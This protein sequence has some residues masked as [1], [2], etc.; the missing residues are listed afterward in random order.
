MKKNNKKDN[1]NSD[2][3]GLG[4]FLDGLDKLVDLVGKLEKE[5][6]INKEK[7]INLDNLKKGMKGVYGFSVRTV[8]GESPTV[9]TFGNIKNTEE[10]PV[11]EDER[12][13]IT[14]FFDE[15][16]EMV[17]TAEMPGVEEENITINL[18]EDILEIS[19]K[20]KNRKYHKEIMLPHKV[21]KQDYKS[22]YNNGILEIRIK[23]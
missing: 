13:P 12:E 19:A 16:E 18:R 7:E 15:K 6:N 5:G 20:A 17:I 22:K 9:E 10:G 2:S 14:D 1:A 11:V 23:K 21:E 8:T 4:S 3:F